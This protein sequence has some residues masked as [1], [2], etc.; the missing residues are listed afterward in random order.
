MSQEVRKFQDGEQVVLHAFVRVIAFDEHDETYEIQF[1][2]GQ[3]FW[4]GEDYLASK[5]DAGVS[6]R[7]LAPLDFVRTRG[8]RDAVGQVISIKKG[9]AWVDWSPLTDDDHS[10][11]V[12][13]SA[14]IRLTN[15]EV[16]AYRKSM[17]K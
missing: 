12:T 2:D 10:S 13:L 15:V 6:D 17:G 11:A 1:D 4:V 14:L 16:T 5:E 7:A 3:E 9:R 8:S